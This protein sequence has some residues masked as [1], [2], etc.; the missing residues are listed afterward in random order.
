MQVRPCLWANRKPCVA[1]SFLSISEQILAC[2]PEHTGS[3]PLPTADE[4]KA[5]DPAHR[6]P[7][8]KLRHLKGDFMFHCHVHH[9]MM[10]GMIGLVRA[11]QSI[12]LTEDMAHEISHR[13][14]LPLDDGTNSCPDVDG[15]FRW[16]PPP[17]RF[18]TGASRSC[19]FRMFSS[20]PRPCSTNRSD[21]SA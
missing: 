17:M 13:T 18:H 2:E 14:G 5:Q 3:A 9:H 7:G 11:R 10:N 8:A 4:E 20:G 1:P 12:W 19:H 6:P 21:R 16:H 15:L